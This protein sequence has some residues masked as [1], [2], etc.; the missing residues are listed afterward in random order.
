MVGFWYQFY[1][2]KYKKGTLEK[3]LPGMIRDNR[4]SPNDQWSTLHEWGYTIEELYNQEKKIE[5]F[6]YRDANTAIISS[7]CFCYNVEIFSR[8]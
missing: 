7:K 6:F 1:V 8:V 4:I 3:V 2:D 5:D